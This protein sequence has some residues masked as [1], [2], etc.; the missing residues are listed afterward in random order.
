TR[1]SGTGNYLLDFGTTQV[2]GLLFDLTGTNGRKMTVEYGEVLASPTSVNYKLSTG[3]VYKDVFTLKSGSQVLQ[4]WGYRVFRYAEVLNSPQPPTA[5]FTA[6]ALTYPD[7][8]SNSSLTT[9]DASL[10]QVWQ[11]S[12]NTI[13]DL[14]T[15]PYTDS[16]TRERSMGDEGDEY[17][18]Q[19]S[20][21][22]VDGDSADARY[23]LLYALT[24]M[25][26]NNPDE[27]ITE[28]RELAPVAALDSYWQ[29]G[30]SAAL[31]SMYSSLQKM[32][33]TVGSNHLV[34]MPITELVQPATTTPQSGQ[35]SLDI[36]Q[37]GDLPASTKVTNYPNT[38]VDWP[39]VERDDFVFTSTNTVVDAFSYA[40]YNAMAQIATVVGQK[41]QAATYAADASGL[42]T[43]IDAQLFDSSTGAFYDGLPTTT[44]HE[45]MDT[46]VYVLALGAASAAQEKAGA[47]FIA[48]HGITPPSAADNGY[49]AC[50]VYCAAYYLEA[51][52][53]GGQP[54]AALNQLTS[55]SETSWLHMISLGAGSTME[56][57]D[58][59][60]K[61]NLTYSHPWA[62]SPAFIVPN[63]LFGIAP[64]TP[65]W[66]SIL[67]A[68]Q[69]GSLT[70]GTMLMPTG[71]GEIREGFT[72]SPGGQ[73]TIT[74][75]V[76]L[77]AKAEIVLPGATQGEQVM[78][79]GTL[80][81]VSPVT[82]SSPLA[83]T[84]GATLYAVQ[85][86]SGDHTISTTTAMA[87]TPPPSTAPATT[88][89]STSAPAT[90]A[91][92]TPTDTPTVPDTSTP[93]PTPT[94]TSTPT[95]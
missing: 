49:A 52:Y 66:G 44:T 1:L 18:H 33:L 13:E 70:S 93:T 67:V 6:L 83:S 73:F 14:N 31:T 69:P 75:G 56:A 43:A 64:L 54:Q 26:G 59:S 5:G 82:T 4:Y 48:A 74:V 46:T 35:P 24:Q 36:P 27:S 68:P 30:D 72:A 2:G 41:T 84:G 89:P 34:T 81:T 20:Q 37:P 57:W 53:D 62:A 61:P 28:Y 19:L 11:F 40:A 77:A 29:T 25:A 7:Q 90:T 55:D 65:G 86:G 80:T 10:D 42:K 17:I 58:P 12:K 22:A 45:S 15:V 85:V 63:D 91:P 21:A 23:S 16:P 79:D 38:L 71:R 39:P 47:A 60:I 78:V 9:S 87:T 94:D 51:L 8:A 50:S 88:D 92:A 95:S 76:P 32:L 3:N